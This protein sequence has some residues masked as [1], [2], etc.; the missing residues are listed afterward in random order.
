MNYQI[1][2]IYWLHVWGTNSKWTIVDGDK[3]KLHNI[4]RGLLYT[5][6]DAGWLTSTE[7]YKAQVVAKFLQD[8][9]FISKWYDLAAEIKDTPFDVVLA[10]AN[11]RNVRTAL[12]HR[13]APVLLHATTGE[14]WLSQLHRHVAGADDC[15]ECRTSEVANLHMECSIGTVKT[16]EKENQ[17]NDAAL[18]FLSATSGL[19][20][21]TLLQ[22]LE[23]GLIME[24]FH[25]DWRFD[26]LSTKRMAS[27]GKRRCRE[28]CA[29]WQPLEVRR[30]ANKG[31]RWLH[32]DR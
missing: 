10:L 16:T 7:S 1:I 3:V 11:E 21:A 20:L 27:A 32:L 2:N 22:K 28:G 12:A 19:M 8:A 26:F 30:C 14:N 25:N 23:A 17:S 4:N 13:N 24:D 15:I 6:S 18:P 9:T 29:I 5:A 31:N